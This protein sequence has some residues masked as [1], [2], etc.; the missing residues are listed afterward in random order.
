[1]LHELALCAGLGGLSLGLQRAGIRTVCYVERDAY[2]IAVLTARMRD[3][4]L[5]RA[6][7]WDDVT[8]FDG[9]PW[10][11]R[12]GLL[13]AG[14]PCQPFSLA[15]RRRGSADTRNLWPDIFRIICEVRPPYLLVENV[16]GLLMAKPGRIA[17]LS[18]ILGDLAGG[19]MMHSGLCYRLPPLAL[20]TNANAS[21]LLPTPTK[22]DGIA[23]SFTTYRGAAACILSGKHQ[24]RWFYYRI[25]YSNLKK[26]WV[27]PRFAEMMMGLPIGWSD[28]QPL[29]RPLSPLSRSPLDAALLPV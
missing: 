12:V 29:A 1:M 18:T 27:N 19:G 9:R 11:G 20:P 15:G 21:S 16:P 8:T 7:I 17:P 10:R 14:F 3:G 4:A 6:P 13:T 2:R 24:K 25:V 23:S 28:L 5:D 26:G 22:S